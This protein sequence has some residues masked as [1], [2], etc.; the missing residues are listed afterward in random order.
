MLTSDA[1]APPHIVPKR[2]ATAVEAGCG[3]LVCAVGDARE[4]RQ[5]APR[6]TI[7]TPGIRPAGTPVHDQA[8]A[9]TPQE[10]FDAGADLLV[11]GRAVTAAEDPVVAAAELV[12]SITL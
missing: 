3:G 7:V 9:A 2:V 11:I 5:L 8:R 1:T 4:A 10:A 12:E 6:L